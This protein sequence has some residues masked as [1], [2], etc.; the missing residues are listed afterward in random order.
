MLTVYTLVVCVYIQVFG[1]LFNDFLKFCS[2]YRSTLYTV[3]EENE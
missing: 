3:P 2:K 1:I